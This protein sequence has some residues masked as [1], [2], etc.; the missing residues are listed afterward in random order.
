MS[1]IEDTT[2]QNSDKGLLAILLSIP[3]GYQFNIKQ[4]TTISSDGKQA[5]RTQ[6]NRLERAGYI[7]RTEVRDNGQYAGLNYKVID[8]LPG[9]VT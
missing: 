4:L 7:K 2:L 6:L 8:T 1:Y 5:I 3:A 9:D